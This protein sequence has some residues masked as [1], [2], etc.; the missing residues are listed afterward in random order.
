MATQ[1]GV[2]KFGKM[3]VA[4]ATVSGTLYACSSPSNDRAKVDEDEASYATAPTRSETNRDNETNSNVNA[5]SSSKSS[6]IGDQNRISD[7]SQRNSRSTTSQSPDTT[8]GRDQTESGVVRSNP[9]DANTTTMTNRDGETTRRQDTLSDRNDQQ[10][11]AQNNSLTNAAD[12]ETV[13]FEF[14]SAELNSEERNKL[15]EFVDNLENKNLSGIQVSISGHTDATGSSEYN[16]GLSKRRAAAVQKYLK[17][18]NLKASAWDIKA[19]GATE[20]TAQN[21]SAGAREQDR[22]VVIT[23]ESQN[24]DAYSMEQ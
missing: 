13:Y 17:E 15:D 5:A 19:E 24:R 23:I 6:S 12:R 8:V 2:F 22:R 10:A 14:D 3:A 4:I 11:R 18:A 7:T 1:K 9:F 20:S 21:D 16:E